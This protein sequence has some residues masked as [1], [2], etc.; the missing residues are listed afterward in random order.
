MTDATTFDR[1]F[2]KDDLPFLVAAMEE[3]HAATP[4]MRLALAAEPPGK[5]DKVQGQMS[6]PEPVTVNANG[7]M[8]VEDYKK[9]STL[10][11]VCQNMVQKSLVNAAKAAK[12]EPDAALKNMNAWLQAYMDFPFPFFN[13]KDSQSK[14][15]KKDDFVLN[16][17]P[18]VIASIVN[19]KDV[20]GLKDAV[21][22]ALKKSQGNLAS[23]SNTKQAFKYFGIITAYNE[24]EIAI[25]V[26]KF[27]MNMEQTD[28]ESLCV[29]AQKT[30]LDSNYDT[31]QFVA[32]KILM[33][34]MQEKMGD[35]VIE[36]MA[37]KLLEF[38][39][40]FYDQQLAAYQQSLE[41]AL[42][43]SP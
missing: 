23:Y 38:V 4:R 28:V 2:T 13:F 24:T 39:K 30:H 16:A 9:C 8:T 40:A 20:A 42:K 33:I 37:D 18:E 29:K 5:N 12:V 15:Y 17:D 14:D 19:I 41:K 25:R 27:A 26:I 7:T 22:G 35:K 21:I 1:P 36:Y 31:Y 32:D 34:K 11:A 6:V 3:K 43:P 10:M